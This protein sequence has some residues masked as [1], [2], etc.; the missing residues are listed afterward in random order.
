MTPAERQPTSQQPGRRNGPAATRAAARAAADP[1]GTERVQTSIFR[2][3]V[4]IAS[5]FG[6]Y[7]ASAMLLP[8]VVDLYY[9]KADWQV[10]ALS[11]FFVG[12][13]S[14]AVALATRSSP[15]PFSKR[16]GFVVVNLLWVSLSLAGA[17]PFYLSSLEIG[18]ADAIFEAVSALTTTGSTALTGLDTMPPGILLWRSL[19]QW[20]GGI[21][22]VALGLFVLPFLRVGGFT[23]FRMESSD[24][25]D[26]PFSRFISFARAM[27]GIYVAFTVICAVLYGL[28]GMGSFDA[29]NHAM[30]TVATGGFST[31]DASFGHFDNVRILWIA[32][33]FMTLSSLPFSILILFFMRGRLDTL[34]DPQIVFFLGNLVVFALALSAYNRIVNDLDF[35]TA[36]SHSTFNIVSI[37]TTTGYSSQDYM[38]WGPFAVA[39]VFFATFMGGCSGSTTGGIKAYRFVI[40]FNTIRAGLNRL[41]YPHGINNVRYGTR[42]VDADTQ[43]AVFLFISA[44]LFLWVIGTLGMA[45][46]GYDFLT[47]ASA[48][49]TALANV[50]PGLGSTVG[51]T[52]SFAPLNDTAKYL[53]AFLMLLGRLEVLTVLVII[54]PVFWKD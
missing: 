23:F 3:A 51:P 40:I 33:V 36:M 46:M 47:S 6:L 16:F 28:A 37:L 50:G 21:G 17:L 27:V 8:A 32:I 5:I 18:L 9:G 34:R 15:P 25:S 26:R 53:L 19:L 7:L 52:G 49:I 41:V 54:M 10:F 11:A 20:M 39:A 29:I 12:G 4:F 14:L 24:T 43:R 45:A 35:V 22:I 42:T 30:T 44:F 13:L 2:S 1:N 38:A 48:A 31:R